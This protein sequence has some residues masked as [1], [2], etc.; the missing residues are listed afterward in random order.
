LT[1]SELNDLSNALAY[2]IRDEYSAR[3]GFD[4]KPD[5]LIA[6]YLDRS[7]EMVIG[8]LGVLKAGGA[9]VPIDTG[10]PQARVDY[11]LSDTDASLVLS[12]RGL[13]DGGSID[14]PSDK[15]LFI[16]LGEG[17]YQRDD[18]SN[19]EG[20]SGSGDLAYV[21]YTSGTTGV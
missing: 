18:V 14:L 15:V 21:I 4:L 13:Q 6:L 3:V 10:Y 7:L 2:Y 1:Y 8:I 20:Y 16:D 5:S 12:Q 11:L 19:P 17:F 9:Y